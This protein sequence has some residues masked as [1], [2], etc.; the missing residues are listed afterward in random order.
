MSDTIEQLPADR[1]ADIIIRAGNDVSVAFELVG[2]TAWAGNAKCKHGQVNNATYQIA[3]GVPPLNHA[4][5]VTHLRRMHQQI[6]ACDCPNEPP[7]LNA[8][9]VFSTATGVAPGQQRYI[10]QSSGTIEAYAKDNLW[11]GPGLTCAKAGAYQ[12]LAKVQLSR[13][14]AQG[15][16]GLGVVIIQGVPVHSVPMTDEGGKATANIDTMLTLLPN[17]SINIGY[18]NTTAVAQDVT[19]TTLTV[20]AVWVP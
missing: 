20:S 1:L 5:M 6:V 15:A 18:E 9:I 17:Q 16:G 4:A 11:W 19:L 10:S 12:L 13:G 7:R 2:Q 3:P 8:T 14:V